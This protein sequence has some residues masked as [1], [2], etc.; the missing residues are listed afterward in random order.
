MLELQEFR[1]PTQ[2]VIDEADDDHT[3]LALGLFAA[4]ANADGYL[5]H[6]E[7]Q[8]YQR[9]ANNILGSANLENTVT[10]VKAL[11]FLL[12]PGDVEQRLR[13]YLQSIVRQQVSQQSCKRVVEQL[14]GLL[15]SAPQSN[16]A[17]SDAVRRLIDELRLPLSDYAARLDQLNRR[18]LQ[19]IE[20]AANNSH[21]P[22]DEA[23]RLFGS[24]LSKMASIWTRPKANKDSTA[25]EHTIRSASSQV[26]EDARSFS[27]RALRIGVSVGDAGIVERTSEFLEQLK[28]QAFRLALVGEMKHGKSSIFNKILG[29]PISPVGESTATTASVVELHYSDFPSYEGRWLSQDHLTKLQEYIGKHRS[30]TRVENYGRMLDFATNAEEFDAAG[31]IHGLDSLGQLRDY[32]T[33]QG[34]LAC[35]VERVRVGLPVEE[36]RHGA[37]IVDTPGI[38]DPMHVRDFIT[39]QEAKRADCV[40]FVMRADKLGTESERQFLLDLLKSGKAIELLVVVTHIDRLSKEAG[41]RVFDTVRQWLCQVADEAG[42]PSLG[43]SASVFGFNASV[44]SVVEINDGFANFREGMRTIA[45]NLQSENDYSRWVSERKSTIQKYVLD[46]VSIYS[47]SMTSTIPDETEIQSLAKMVSRFG[48]LAETYHD[49]IAQRMKSITERLQMDF[50]HLIEDLDRFKDDSINELRAEVERLVRQAGDDY[51]KETVWKQFDSVTSAKIVGSRLQEFSQRIRERMELWNSEFRRF[52]EENDNLIRQKLSELQA[53]RR[54]FFG[55]TETNHRLVSNMCKLD[56]AVAS[57]ERFVLGGATAYAMV[58]GTLLMT[59]GS[60]IFFTAAIT[61][62]TSGTAFP[63]IAAVSATAWVVHRALSDPEK[64]KQKFIEQKMDKAK[65]V[66]DRH[67]G[68]LIATIK[69]DMQNVWEAFRVSAINS[70]SQLVQEAL[71]SSEEARLQME[72]ANRIRTDSQNQVAQIRDA[73]TN[74]S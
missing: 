25:V 49:Q 27:Q 30:N 13:A 56:R 53:T 61:L 19:T 29:Q 74:F 39:L 50:Q 26:N 33:S 4:I 37:V 62:L 47:D 38:N 73:L 15:E 48:K 35:A 22:A 51:H 43:R 41:E 52:S 12:H 60:S 71:A 68:Q 64:R 58:G 65:L 69:T 66:L 21:S 17:G 70:H 3:F 6:E 59:T 24:T 63:V 40:V 67:F 34:S 8:A 46:Q 9:T 72:I 45:A 44:D 20:V 31:P 14:L 16:T 10:R 5:L 28:P 32:V 7:F 1:I 54:E 23:R 18:L 11:R 55:I 42:V 57:A 2:L 36:L